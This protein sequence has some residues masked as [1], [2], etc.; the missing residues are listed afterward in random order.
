MTS[1]LDIANSTYW[2]TTAAGVGAPLHRTPEKPG[3]KTTDIKKTSSSKNSQKQGM[4]L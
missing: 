1:D 4:A 2:E 3:L